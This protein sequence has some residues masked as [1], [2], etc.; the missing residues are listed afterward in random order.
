MNE[1]TENNQ[2]GGLIDIS[3]E[4]DNDYSSDDS[5]EV[6]DAD[7]DDE[8]KLMISSDAT[9]AAIKTISL[10]I[11]GAETGK[12]N[13]SMGEVTDLEEHSLEDNLE[14][15][16]ERTGDEM[17]DNEEQ[18]PN[19][20]QDNDALNTLDAIELSDA[21]DNV[22]DADSVD[23]SDTKTTVTQETAHDFSKMNMTQLKAVA[24]QK[25]LSNFKGLRKQKLIDLLSANQ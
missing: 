16:Q 13:V 25:G 18:E 2:N 7:D 19:Q 3:D 10:S 22:T 23:N 12:T 6:S 21:E 14:D 8:D 20:E 11:D 9:P 4:E 24:G 17:T 5:A 1:H 15:A